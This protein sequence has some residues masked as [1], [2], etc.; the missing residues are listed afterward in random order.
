MNNDR[1]YRMKE[2]REVR[3]YRSVCAGRQ[4][5]SW[6]MRPELGRERRKGGGNI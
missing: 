6:T 3:E 5:K 1:M 4:F 2:K